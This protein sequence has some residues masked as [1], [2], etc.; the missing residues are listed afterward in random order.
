[1]SANR[2]PTTKQRSDIAERLAQNQ[3]ITQPIIDC[4][5]RWCSVNSFTTARTD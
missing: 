3:F 1:M 5:A 2:R 4:E